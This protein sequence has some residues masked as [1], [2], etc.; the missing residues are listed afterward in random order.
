MYWTI[1]SNRK[2][3]Q[4]HEQRK[5][6]AVLA[7]RHANLVVVLGPVASSCQ[8]LGKTVTYSAGLIGNSTATNVCSWDVMCH[9]VAH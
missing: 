1:Q 7:P 9:I 6:G 4:S 3:R 5:R 8:V 2:L